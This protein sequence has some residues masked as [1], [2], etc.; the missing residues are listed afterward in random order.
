MLGSETRVAY[1]EMR[2]SEMRRV[3]SQVFVPQAA[4]GLEAV[5]IIPHRQRHTRPKTHTHGHA[6]IVQSEWS[7]MGYP[8]LREPN[9]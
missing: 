5:Q 8:H 1:E 6:A 2:L 3:H 9:R 4:P 7:D